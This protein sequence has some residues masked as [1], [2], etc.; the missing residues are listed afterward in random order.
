MAWGIEK[1]LACSPAGAAAGLNRVSLLCAPTERGP[2]SFIL[3]PSALEIGMVSGMEG[4]GSPPHGVI[5]GS[6]QPV[7]PKQSPIDPA[8]GMQPP[9]GATFLEDGFAFRRAQK[10]KCSHVV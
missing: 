3:V 5:Q 4:I 8:Q 6:P 9:T 7:C 2:L 1:D 10:L